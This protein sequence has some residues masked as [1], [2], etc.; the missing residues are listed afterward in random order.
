MPILLYRCLILVLAHTSFASTQTMTFAG[1][2]DDDNDNDV[3]Y[4]I[5]GEAQ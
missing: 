3:T 1:D 4:L 2:N 5:V